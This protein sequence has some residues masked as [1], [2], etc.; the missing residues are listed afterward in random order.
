LDDYIL[1][2]SKYYKWTRLY[3][4]LIRRVNFEVKLGYK[5]PLTCTCI[6]WSVGKSIHI[7]MGQKSSSYSYISTNQSL[8]FNFVTPHYI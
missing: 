6:K 8:S 4:L 2:V 3:E 5:S 7:S 1:Q